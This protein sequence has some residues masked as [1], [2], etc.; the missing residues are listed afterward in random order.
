[1]TSVLM[2]D[3]RRDVYSAND[4]VGRTITVGE[5]ISYLEG[6]A[7]ETP[8]ILNNDNGYTFGKITTSTMWEDDVEEEE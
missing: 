3:G 4:L 5:L 8:V 1:M 2:I 6:Y 7:D